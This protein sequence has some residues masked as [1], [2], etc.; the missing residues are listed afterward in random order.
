M[1]G[2]SAIAAMATAGEQRIRKIVAVPGD[3]SVVPIWAMPDKRIC[4]S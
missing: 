4:V 2:G 1:N 3:G